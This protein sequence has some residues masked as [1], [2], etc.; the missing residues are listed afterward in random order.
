VITI[1]TPTADQPMGMA[2]AERWMARQTVQ[3]AQWIVADDGTIPATLTMGQ[4]HIVRPRQ[5]EGARSLAG[6]IL[7][8]L[9]H[10]RGDIVAIIEHDDWY[11]PDHL[12]TCISGLDYAEITGSSKQRYYHIGAQRWIVMRNIGSALCNTAIRATSLKYLESAA[13]T[14]L[15]KN[16]IGLDRMLWDSLNGNGNITES[17]TVVGIKGLPGRLGLG[18]GHRPNASPKWTSDPNE[19]QLKAWIGDDINLYPRSNPCPQQ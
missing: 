10:V 19:Y 15:Q 16:L 12:E 11:S 8:A 17:E 3:P 13:H 5:H 4:E 2:L 18:M 7:A 6:N 1:I 9:P 14:A